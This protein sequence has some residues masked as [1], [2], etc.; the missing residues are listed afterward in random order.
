MSSCFN[1][2]HWLATCSLLA[3][4]SFCGMREAW[5]SMISAMHHARVRMWKP[6]SAAMTWQKFGLLRL[7]S[8]IILS[9][10]LISHSLGLSL[11][12]FGCAQSHTG[13]IAHVTLLQRLFSQTW[14]WRLHASVGLGPKPLQM[15]A[16]WLTQNAQT[17][18]TRPNVPH[19]RNL[20][21]K[22]S[23]FPASRSARASSKCV[24]PSASAMMAATRW[25]KTLDQQCVTIRSVITGSPMFHFVDSA[26]PPEPSGCRESGM[27]ASRTT[28]LV[29]IVSSSK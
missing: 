2:W 29:D 22:S 4:I 14:S 12:Y 3:V 17:Q 19:M 5:P 27:M 26:V 25:L 13:Y 7:R 18:Y 15:H 11:R 6:M 9:N 23:M 24:S 21:L 8:T 1:S 28:S 16:C 10:L 20:A